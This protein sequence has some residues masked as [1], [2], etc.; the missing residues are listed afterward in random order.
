MKIE[1][2][3]FGTEFAIKKST[4]NQNL[5]T[6]KIKERMKRVI[7]SLMAVATVAVV[8]TSCKPDKTPE[9]LLQNSKGWKLQS[10]MST[11]AYTNGAGVT[12]TNLFESW[13]LQCEQ[14]D[15][16]FFDKSNA[17]KVQ[18]GCEAKKNK[19]TTGTWSLTE[20]EEFP[21]KLNFRIHFFEEE[22]GSPIYSDVE[23]TELSED[24]FKYN[25]RWN[26]GETS[27]IFTMTYVPNK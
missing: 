16:V 9:E 3:K 13:F 23:V 21:Y 12:S 15:V 27:Y 4:I 17:T 24:V 6:K 18:H 7:L 8:F 20:T 2:E 1:N 14:N 19:Q 5:I 26:D 11:P 10:A 25:Y 22:D